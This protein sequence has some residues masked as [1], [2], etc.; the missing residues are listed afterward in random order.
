MQSDRGFI[1]EI[2][3]LFEDGT[4]AG[5]D[6]GALLERFSSAHDELALSAIVERHGPMV[7]GVCR[8]VLASPHDVEDAFQATFLILVRKVRG[9]RDR[10]HL[11][12]WLHAVAY[13]VAARARSD[14]ARRPVSRAGERFAGGMRRITTRSRSLRRKKRA[15]LRSQWTTRLLACR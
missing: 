5:Q 4:I 9:L 7:L 8:H 1:G 12:P 15:M 13:R 2:N 14:A 3:R 11:G 10:H 6:E